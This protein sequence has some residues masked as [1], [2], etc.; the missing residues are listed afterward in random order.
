MDDYEDFFFLLMNCLYDSCPWTNDEIY[1]IC[2]IVCYNFYLNDVNKVV[3]WF[4]F[5]FLFMNCKA[6]HGNK[7]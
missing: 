4:F 1:L 3:N 2:L 5:F 6:A 7:K